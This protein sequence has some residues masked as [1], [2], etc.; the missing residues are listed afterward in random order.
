[1]TVKGYEFCITLIIDNFNS[2]LRGYQLF[3]SCD[4]IIQQ[5]IYVFVVQLKCINSSW[6]ALTG[7]GRVQLVSKE[8]LPFLSSLVE[9]PTPIGHNPIP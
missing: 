3:L 4:T 8:A 6:Q 7:Q 5:S 1:M 9:L 2:I